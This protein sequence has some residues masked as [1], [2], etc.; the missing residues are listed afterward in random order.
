MKKEKIQLIITGI[1]V[2]ILISAVI[3]LI[4]KG[5]KKTKKI[6]AIASA[7]PV[8]KKGLG[9][10]ERLNDKFAQ[11]GWRNNSFDANV[12]KVVGAR[13]EG[14]L[15][16]VLWDLRD[17]TAIFG[18]RFLKRGDRIWEYRILKVKEESVILSDGEKIY[19]LLLGQ[20]LDDLK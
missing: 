18:D 16:G 8:G 19:E 13:S 7:K 17:P 14:Y 6:T 2:V 5:F 11:M 15:K 9:L 12:I 3:N 20:S 1:L 10:Y 4:S